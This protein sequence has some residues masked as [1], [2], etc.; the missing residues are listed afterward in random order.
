[1]K[2][3]TTIKTIGTIKR[4]I[5][6]RDGRKEVYCFNN[7]AL[8]TGK[9]VFALT[10]ANQLE[11]PPYITNM[12]FGDGGTQNQKLQEVRSNRQRMFGITRVSKPVVVHVDPESPTQVE[13]TAVIEYQEATDQVLN[14][15]ALELSN[16]DLFS[17]AVFQDLHK[18][19]DMRVSWTWALSFI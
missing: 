2:V 14:E 1:M 16:G 7:A 12:L 8:T 17:M 6:Y 15:M 5:E 9:S 18:T 13:F 11:S 19:D 10:L 4:I 3:G